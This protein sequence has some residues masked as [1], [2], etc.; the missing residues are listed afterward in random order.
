MIVVKKSI[1]VFTNFLKIGMEYASWVMFKK[2][3]ESSIF[4]L[5]LVFLY[6]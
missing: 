3:D 1:W 6:N 2:E 4:S 5:L